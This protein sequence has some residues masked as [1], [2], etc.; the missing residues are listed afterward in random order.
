MISTLK[1]R[2]FVM[3]LALPCLGAGPSKPGTDVAVGGGIGRYT[4]FGICG[5]P[6]I[7]VR[8]V[9][10][11]GKA[12]HQFQGGARVVV[13]GGHSEGRIRGVSLDG[14]PQ[15]TAGTA[16][17]LNAPVKRSALA[18]RVGGAWRYG[19]FEAG[20]GW[21]AG[22]TGWQR[23]GWNPVPAG[24]SLEAWTGHP[25]YGYVW[26]RYRTGPL[27]SMGVLGDRE[28]LIAV[29]LGYANEY[30]RFE[31]GVGSSGLLVEGDMR[32]WKGLRFG[33]SSHV[34]DERQWTTLATMGLHFGG[35]KK[36]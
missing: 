14:T 17:E 16:L 7:D 1:R 2:L 21:H 27:V 33:L 32:A 22:Q 36:E 26:G 35:E 15:D 18:A 5:A 10:V 8:D 25:D 24:P 9:Q 20:L 30:V 3:L 12:S 29:G 13:E 4:I 19:G 11:Y 6:S 31:S 23:G 34:S 28:P